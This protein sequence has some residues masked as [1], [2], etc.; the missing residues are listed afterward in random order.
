MASNLYDVAI[1]EATADDNGKVLMVDEGKWEKKEIG[2]SYPDYP[3]DDGTY[4][5]SLTV[6]DGEATLAWVA[7]DASAES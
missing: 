3:E 6:A 7:Q 5:L 4:V 2:S 1:P